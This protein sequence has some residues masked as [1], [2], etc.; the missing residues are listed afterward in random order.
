MF[1]FF[2][3]SVLSVLDVIVS[4]W[5]DRQWNETFARRSN[6]A[7]SG[8]LNIRLFSI[9]KKKKKNKRNTNMR[10]YH[11][12]MMIW[13]NETLAT[14]WVSMAVMSIVIIY[15]AADWP[16]GSFFKLHSATGFLVLFFICYFLFVFFLHF[17][18]LLNRNVEMTAR[19]IVH[20]FSVIDTLSFASWF[21]ISDRN[22]NRWE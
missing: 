20:A 17:H 4:S 19:Q 11:W 6:W 3:S 13:M 1:S 22:E 7:I 15:F 16:N 12:T 14:L 18:W 10:K 21:R 5:R 8:S 2:F 9:K